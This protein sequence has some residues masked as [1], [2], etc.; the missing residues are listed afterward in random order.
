MPD[1]ASSRLSRL[2]DRA[3]RL[4]PPVLAVIGVLIAGGV[5]GGGYY[6]YRTYE[7][8]Q[9][10]NDFCMSCHLM[11][12]PFEQ[13]ARSAHQ[14]LGCKACHRPNPLERGQ[15][16]LT[17]IVDDPEVISV[18]AE[19]PNET[20][21]E[22]HIGG[23]PAAWRIIANSAGH[24][25]H[26]ESEE[27]TGLQC[28][29]CHS[30]S[31]HEFAPTD[32]TCAQS[33]CHEDNVMRLGAM[34]ELTVHC[35]AC[36]TFVAPAA[37]RPGILGDELD[38]AMLPDFDECLSCHVMRT[39]VSMP[40]PDP[41]EGGCAACHNPHEQTEPAQAVESCASAGCHDDAAEVSPFHRGIEEAVLTDCLSCHRAHDFSLDGADC[42]SCHEGADL[43]APAEGLFDFE[44]GEHE[45]VACGDCHAEG[46]EHGLASVT[47][48]QDCRACHH[49][50]P[51]STPCADCHRLSEL[52]RDT[53][54]VTRAVTF[55]VGAGDPA[56]SLAFPHEP[57]A[58]EACTTCH[59]EGLALSP[60]PDLDCQS[61]HQ[62]HHTPEAD[63]ASCHVPAPV[64]AHPP[65]EAHV[66]CSGSGCHEAIPFEGLPRT[67]AL[68]L[69][70]HQDLRDHEPGGRCEDCHQLPPPRAPGAPE[71]PY[72]RVP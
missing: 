46:E 62:D 36:H 53:Y 65:S 60:P 48:V 35:A 51:A 54:R 28:V 59:T 3:G 47:E 12:E 50:Q 43:R 57:H 68:C 70:C 17:A 32:R 31:I 21:A 10:D 30:T 27:L 45:S 49:A 41:H 72:T 22:C 29:E 33:A 34:G 38:A 55:S 7:Y 18:H 6:A 5:A 8:V 37:E 9:Y 20:C 11:A 1:R 42:A 19:V 24:R 69:A 56:R 52:P 44:H 67:R 63:C 4:S 2:A 25:V 66:T 71:T 13:F 23:D 14:G 40:D 15:M 26:L 16:G 58:G 39:L 61:C 64:G